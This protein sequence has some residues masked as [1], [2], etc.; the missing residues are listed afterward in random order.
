MQGLG[1]CGGNGLMDLIF[2]FFTI[3]ISPLSTSLKNF[4]PMMSRAQVSEAKTN[5]LFFYQLPKLIPNGSLLNQFL[6]SS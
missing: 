1:F 4:A 6:V 5:E 2:S 3:T